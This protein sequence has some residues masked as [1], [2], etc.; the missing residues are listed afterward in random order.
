MTSD[1][2]KK[3][4]NSFVTRAFIVFLVVQFLILPPLPPS[5]RETNQILGVE[6][7]RLKQRRLKLQDNL[8]SVDF[9]V[10]SDHDLP[11]GSGS[12]TILGDLNAEMLQYGR[13]KLTQH[14]S[15]VTRLQKEILD[16]L[17]TNAQQIVTLEKAKYSREMKIPG[18]DVVLDEAKVRTYY[19][20]GLAIMLIALVFIYRRPL[21]KSIDNN[22]D[23]LPPF[24]AAPLAYGKYGLGF[25]SCTIR[26]LL[27]LGLV[28]LIFELFLE[29]SKRF[30][31]FFVSGT[32]YVFNWSAGVIAVVTY[33]ILFFRALF[34]S[35][36][37]STAV[38]K[39]K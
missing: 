14:E 27:G 9:L 16:A 37:G 23:A 21:L 24:W 38:E 17:A 8:K 18:T 13:R 33:C 36:W 1:E 2:L 11:E 32:F 7:S 31:E 12:S 19:A 5:Q 6:V 28:L 15:D 25:W 22:R 20:S 39:E 4:G 10:R 3:N 29:S 35:N 30:A 34:S 26:N